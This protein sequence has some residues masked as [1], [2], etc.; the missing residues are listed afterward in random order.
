MALNCSNAFKNISRQD[1]TN[2]VNHCQDIIDDKANAAAY[3]AGLII[4]P[5]IDAA[6]IQVIHCDM[7]R[8]MSSTFGLQLSEEIYKVIL[9]I[10]VRGGG[11]NYL[12]PVIGWNLLKY[13]PIFG[14]IIG[15]AGACQR[16]YNDTQRLG[17]A[18]LQVLSSCA[19]N[20][21]SELNE[22]HIKKE[23]PRYYQMD[24]L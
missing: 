19:S 18:Y 24:N 4:I 7:L 12:R 22:Y 14:T 16:A 21:L 5:L 15:G 20:S 6:P 10:S 1:I 11:F 8:L 23:F 9:D 2:K 13:V 3:A 17:K